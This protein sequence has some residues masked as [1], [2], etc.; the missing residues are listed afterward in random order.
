MPGRL[1][2]GVG[3]LPG[4]GAFT[5]GRVPGGTP[6]RAMGIDRGRARDAPPVPGSVRWD[7]GVDLRSGMRIRAAGGQRS[8]LARAVG[9]VTLLRAVIAGSVGSVAACALVVVD[10][11]QSADPAKPTHAASIGCTSPGTEIW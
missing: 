11:G 6:G 10:V 1:L 7:G 9:A 8:G 4:F 2:P 3:V 5:P